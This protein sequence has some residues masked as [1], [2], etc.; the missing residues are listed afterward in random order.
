MSAPILTIARQELANGLR[1]KWVAASV[2][3]MVLFSLSLA[4]LGSAPAGELGAGPLEVLLVSLAGL[5]VFLL[6][7]IALFLAHDA[8]VGEAERGTLLLTLAYPVARWQLLAGKFLGHSAILAFAV[9]LG[10]G[11]AAA[12]VVA[13][14]EANA[15]AWPAILRLVTTAVMM[16]A[17]FLALGYVV[18]ALVAERSTAVGVAV[19]L[20]LGFVIVYDLAFLGLLVS[21]GETL[22]GWVVQAL[23]LLNP[24]DAFRLL[25]LGGSE[26][27]SLGAGTDIA[28]MKS[29]LGPGPLVASLVVW[30]AAGLSL[31]WL[32]FKR[33]E[34]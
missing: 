23:I 8:I 27:V 18:S 13:G 16:G 25:N 12:A 17:V 21:L 28:G 20:W 31:A 34:I 4:L 6:P 9:L 11:A 3:A 15:G 10:Y 22:P 1:N 29:G 26:A 14:G 32:A 30:L 19:G 24:A 5:L 2:L 7:L 33:R